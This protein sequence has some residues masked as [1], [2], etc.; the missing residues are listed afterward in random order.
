MNVSESLTALSFPIGQV[1][2]QD[3]DNG[4]ICLFSTFI[5]ND[6]ITVD[7]MGYVFLTRSL[8]YEQDSQYDVAIRVSDGELESVHPGQI[9]INVIDENDHNP[10][11]TQPVFHGRFPENSSPGT[12]FIDVLASDMDTSP[13]NGNID[14]Y[15]IQ[16]AGLPF[17]IQNIPDGSAIIS[18]SRSMDYETNR[19]DYVLHVHA[20]DSGGLRSLFPAQVIITLQDVDDCGPRFSRAEYH[21]SVKENNP[22]SVFVISLLASDCDISVPF[23]GIQYKVANGQGLVHIDPT[24][25]Q[26]TAAKSY[27]FESDQSTTIIEVQAFDRDGG[28]IYGVVSKYWM[29]PNRINGLPF[30]LNSSSGELFLT[31]ALDYENG[32]TGFDIT[33]VAIDGGSYLATATVSIS[34]LNENDEEP[35]FLTEEEH[36]ISIP[37]ETFPFSI[38]GLPDNVL[39]HVKAYDSDLLEDGYLYYNLSTYEIFSI[40]SSGY[41]YLTV[42]LDYEEKDQHQVTVSVGDGVFVARTTISI[43]VLVGN[44]NDHPPVFHSCLDGC[45]E[46]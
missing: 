5:P 24:S 2:A 38:H 21:A 28:E 10:V 8:D 4:A 3:S 11:F 27:D 43:Q 16:E 44:I 1:Y 25:G 7:S 42:P 29:L 40:D 46:T 12:L 37:E 17:Y 41:L 36:N 22:I 20:F 19:R 39:F 18:N 45:C 13:M 32:D 23:R 9:I 35:Y 26:V 30:R 14:R 6:I 33:V 15:E 31:R 34:I